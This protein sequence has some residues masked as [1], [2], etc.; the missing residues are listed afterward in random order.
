[1]YDHYPTKRCIGRDWYEDGLCYHNLKLWTCCGQ[2]GTVPRLLLSVV[3][4]GLDWPGLKV[5]NKPH[6]LQA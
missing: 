1:M 5:P 2:L 6:S 3:W 4:P